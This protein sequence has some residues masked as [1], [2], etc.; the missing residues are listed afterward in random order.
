MRKYALRVDSNQAPIVELLRA[1]GFQ[2]KIIGKPFDL[3][4]SRDKKMQYAEVKDPKK[5][6]WANEFTNAQ[7]KF[8]RDWQGPE[9]AILRTHE[10]VLKY[11]L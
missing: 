8:L 2:V 3:L 4:I 6:G 5:Q 9:I 11:E 10:D 7:K 1:R